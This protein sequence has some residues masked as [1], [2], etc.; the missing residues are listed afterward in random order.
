[1]KWLKAYHTTIDSYSELN[2]YRTTGVAGIDCPVMSVLSTTAKKS[3]TGTVSIVLGKKTWFSDVFCIFLPT[4]QS[5]DPLRILSSF[6]TSAHQ[7]YLV[8]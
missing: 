6:V 7:F 2:Y 8:N 3:L 5:V 1:M 4:S